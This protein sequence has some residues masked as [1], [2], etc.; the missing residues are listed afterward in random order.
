MEMLAVIILLIMNEDPHGK[1]MI[2]NAI[3]CLNKFNLDLLGH[4]CLL[5]RLPSTFPLS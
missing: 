2:G 3:E 1:T 4:L 5:P